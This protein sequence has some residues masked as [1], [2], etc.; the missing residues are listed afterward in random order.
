MFRPQGRIHHYTLD[1]NHYS[2]TKWQDFEY[3]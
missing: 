2:F 3:A 1:N